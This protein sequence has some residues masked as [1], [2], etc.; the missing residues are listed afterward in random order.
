[1]SAA[2]IKGHAGQGYGL[3][4]SIR[5]PGVLAMTFAMQE[6]TLSGDDRKVHT[7][8]I[9][10]DKRH[11]LVMKALLNPPKQ[12]AAAWRSDNATRLPP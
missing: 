7:I 1:M 5:T 3:H 11:Y 4:S 6:T 12:G 9:G 8:R 2:A 10:W